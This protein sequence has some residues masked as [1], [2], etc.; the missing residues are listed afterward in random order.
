M[1]PVHVGG[2]ILGV[3]D[4][5]SRQRTLRNQAEL[6]ALQTLA[7][8]LGTVMRNAQLYGQVVQARRSRSLSLVRSQ[9]LAGVSRQL[10]TSLDIILGY[11]RTALVMP[12]PSKGALPPELVEDLRQAERYG[13]DLRLLIDSLLDLAQAE[14]GVLQLQLE[15]IDTCSFL[16]EVF[17]AAMRIFAAGAGV[18]WRLQRRRI[19]R[20]S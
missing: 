20:R 17:A 10:R 15:Q 11:F 12:G 1:L 9:Q 8:E 7:D 13:G 6:D 4:L 16:E 18:R 3:L 14:T 19:C 2:R 5:H